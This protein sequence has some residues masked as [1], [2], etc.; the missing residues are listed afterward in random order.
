MGS[1]EINIKSIPLGEDFQ[2]SGDCHMNRR[3]RRKAETRER[4]FEAAINLLSEK[5]F[6]S[7][8][9]EMIT[10][11]ADVGKG[12]FFNYFGNKEAVISY[13]FEAQLA[14]ISEVFRNTLANCSDEEQPAIGVEVSLVGGKFWRKMVSM[15][16]QV[17]LRRNKNR[18]FTRT[19]LSLSL[20]N[21]DVRAASLK[22]RK[23]L[24]VVLS[25]IVEKAQHENEL[26]SDI[27]AALLTEYL[28]STHTG[29]LF[30]WAESEDDESLH[31]MINRA[32]TS[33]WEG[34]RP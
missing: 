28:Y 13:F 32:Y 22:F 31:E 12:T 20:T 18:R 6:D 2:V 1:S 29:A 16:H 4:L 17:A 23:S 7:V 26:R 34:V 24:I 33:I 8:T 10:E 21:P 25:D 30:R 9:V 15:V 3:D 19:L 27:P 11:T 5:D 14:L